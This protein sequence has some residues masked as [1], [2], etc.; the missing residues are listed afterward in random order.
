MRDSNIIDKLAKDKNGVKCLLVHQDLFDRTVDAKGMKTKD[1]KETV[2]TFSEINTKKERPKKNWVDQG[3]EF[4]GEFKT[5]C[6][7]EEIEIYP[8]MSETKQHLQNVQYAHSRTFFNAKWR[9]MGTSIF[10][11]YLNLLQQ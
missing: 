6:R 1:S 2:K 5:F 9:I 10:I 4:A 3:R 11:I 7:P 8:T